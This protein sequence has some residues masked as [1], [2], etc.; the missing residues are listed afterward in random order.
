M[1]LFILLTIMALPFLEIVVFV[2]VGSDIGAFAVALL[3]FLTAVI[4]IWLVRAQGLALLV[5]AQREL[6]AGRMP[7]AEMAHGALLALAGLLLLL[8]GLITDTLGA[9]LLLAPVRD[10]VIA[11]AA[12][13]LAVEEPEVV[14]LSPDE[15]EEEERVLPPRQRHPFE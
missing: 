7:V 1:G 10:L 9:L 13:H 2:K 8:P 11:A 6:D 12:R 3:T 4:G 15:W 14:V 5:R